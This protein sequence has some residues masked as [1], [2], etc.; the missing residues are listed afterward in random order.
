[1]L[2]FE[3]F[4]EQLSKNALLFNFCTFLGAH[5]LCCAMNFKKGAETLVLGVQDMSKGSDE[6]V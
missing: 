3:G 6:R 2:C 5:Y 4:A 1:M